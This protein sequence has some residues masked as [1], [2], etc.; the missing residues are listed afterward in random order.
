MDAPK[1][2]N[3]TNNK[4]IEIHVLKCVS[5]EM[6]VCSCVR[7]CARARACVSVRMHACVWVVVVMVVGAFSLHWADLTEFLLVV[8]AYRSILTLSG[9]QT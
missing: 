1:N 5:E 7:V 4:K 9:E 2:L 8:L 6:C 3:G